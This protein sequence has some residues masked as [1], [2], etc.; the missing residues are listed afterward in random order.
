MLHRLSRGSPIAPWCTAVPASCHPW[1]RAVPGVNLVPFFV[2]F[3]LMCG[4][5]RQQSGEDEDGS[6]IDVP[7]NKVVDCVL[8]LLV[9]RQESFSPAAAAAAT[10]AQESAA[11][12]SSPSTKGA[13]AEVEVDEEEENEDEG[14][15]DKVSN[16]LQYGNIF[17]LF[18]E[19]F[20]LLCFGGACRVYVCMYVFLAV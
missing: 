13:G 10:D 5:L 2:C 3:M 9:A 1:L 19:V 20:F 18:F 8:D 17:V 6:L 15:P 4:F 11:I 12:E 7:A 16:S 14:T